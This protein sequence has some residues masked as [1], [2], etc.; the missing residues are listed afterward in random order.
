MET[1]Q[2]TP[3]PKK[4]EDVT[5]LELLQKMSARLDG[6][7]RQISSSPIM[8][9]SD[10]QAP[11]QMGSGPTTA[12]SKRQ[13]DS[14][15]CP[16]G[17]LLGASRLT[18]Q[19]LHQ[20]QRANAGANNSTQ[21]TLHAQAARHHVPQPPQSHPGLDDER[22]QRGIAE[23]GA[24][25]IAVP[26]TKTS[27]LMIQ[28]FTG[29]KLYA[30]LGSGFRE[31]AFSFLEALEMAEVATGYRWA[32]CV[33]VNKLGEHLDKDSTASDYFRQNVAAW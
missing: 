4:D 27:K 19:Y 9:S 33:K 21:G 25:W 29:K 16:A 22:I 8:S 14:R 11:V 17:G 23:F 2:S 31:W 1:N 15:S 13:R 26:D 32:V 6:L 5:I 30:G 3:E 10:G 7:E 24:A 28:R 18:L 20:G 12:S